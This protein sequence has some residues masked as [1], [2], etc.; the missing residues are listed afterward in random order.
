MDKTVVTQ[1]LSEGPVITVIPNHRRV[2]YLDNRSGHKDTPE[3]RAACA[4]I[5]IEIGYFVLN[6]R[7]LIQPCNGFTILEIRRT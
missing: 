5:N 1:Q 7:Y 6:I 4:K 2:T 3:I